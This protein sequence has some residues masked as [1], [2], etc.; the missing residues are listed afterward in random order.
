MQCRNRN[1]F[2]SF[3][4]A[5][6]LHAWISGHNVIQAKW[7]EPGFSWWFDNSVVTLQPKRLPLLFINSHVNFCSTKVYIFCKLISSC[8]SSHS[9]PV[10]LYIVFTAI[11]YIPWQLLNNFVIS[12]INTLLYTVTVHLYDQEFYNKLLLL[13]VHYLHCLCTHTHSYST[14]LYNACIKNYVIQVRAPQQWNENCYN[15]WLVMTT[16][17]SLLLLLL[18]LCH[19]KLE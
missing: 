19:L 7:C 1:F 11:R 9:A 10:L 4:A 13:I 17:I 14:T 12:H 6:N 18:L 15:K 2:Y 16:S 8:S 3:I 5:C